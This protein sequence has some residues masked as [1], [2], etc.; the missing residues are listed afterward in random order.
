MNIHRRLKMYKVA[1]HVDRSTVNGWESRIAG[2]EK[3]QAE[4]SDSRLSGPQTVAYPGILF[5]RGLNKFS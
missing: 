1:S 4:R 3:E 5:G 2:S